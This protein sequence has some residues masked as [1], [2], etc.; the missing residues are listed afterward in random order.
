[1]PKHLA[2]RLRKAAALAAPDSI[3]WCPLSFARDLKPK[4]KRVKTEP[5]G[6]HRAVCY[7]DGCPPSFLRRSAGSAGVGQDHSKSRLG[8]TN[9]APPGSQVLAPQFLSRSARL[10]AK[11]DT[12]SV[13]RG[14]DE[15]DA[16]CLKDSLYS[17]ERILPVM[18][19]GGW[20]SMN[21]VGRYVQEAS[22]AQNGI[23]QLLGASHSRF[24]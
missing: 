20:R 24:R 14:A 15:F 8:A 11:P 4:S 7:A 2:K 10:R 6:P 3:T 9:G 5:G 1:M 16:G 12:W 22:V 21:I 18:R 17:L 23:A 19:A 13:G